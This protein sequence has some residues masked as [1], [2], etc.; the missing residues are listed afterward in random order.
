[1]SET[2]L[3]ECPSCEG[4]GCNFPDPEDP[5]LHAMCGR[6]KGRGLVPKPDEKAEDEAA[7]TERPIGRT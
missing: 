3:V 6:C 5:I 2:R 1:M 7:R 4:T